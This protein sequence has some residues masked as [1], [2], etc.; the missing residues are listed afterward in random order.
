MWAQ[1]PA[2]SVHGLTLDSIG[3]PIG[4]LTVQLHSV[5]HPSSA[6][7][8]RRDPLG[9]F[10]F[11]GIE[12]G[13]Y[14]LSAVAPGFRQLAKSIRVEAGK[15]FD[16]GQL[17]LPI[18]PNPLLKLESSPGS[19]HVLTVCEALE[20]WDRYNLETVVIV[21]IFKS[22][23][24]ET[25]RQ[26]CDH[27]LKTGEVTWPNAIALSNAATPPDKL[28][29]E[30][31]KKR[32]QLLAGYP[33]GA[34]PRSE[35]IVGLYG[36]LALLAGLTSVVCCGGSVETTVAPARLLDPSEREDFSVIR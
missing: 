33:P 30:I 29:E 11:S 32:A 34:Q 13:W 14:I 25:L 27:Q 28:R 24:D 3:T 5:E 10:R 23:M 21:G 2:G 9:Q 7:I 1:T 18:E 8:V 12:P 16:A 20:G 6:S 19:E 22:G 26:D 17:R 4:G 35:R 31:E 15:D 36:R